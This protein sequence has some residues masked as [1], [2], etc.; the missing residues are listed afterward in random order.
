MRNDPT[1]IKQVNHVIHEIKSLTTE[2]APNFISLRMENRTSCVIHLLKE[3]VKEMQQYFQA[4]IPVVWKL[5]EI[6]ESSSN[7]HP[8]ISYYDYMDDWKHI[9]AD[10]ITYLNQ[11]SCHVTYKR[12]YDENKHNVVTHIDPTTEEICPGTEFCIYPITYI[13]ELN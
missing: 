3:L 9:V 12:E 5:P 13:K 6:I 10:V 7:H 4:G 8:K 11:A 1:K 2:Y